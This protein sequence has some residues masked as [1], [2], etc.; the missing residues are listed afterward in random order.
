MTYEEKDKQLPLG[1][2]L[3]RMA[4]QEIDAYFGQHGFFWGC[5]R[6]SILLLVVLICALIVWLLFTAPPGSLGINAENIPYVQPLH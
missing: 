1:V 6:I 5:G 3:R 2:M 4:R